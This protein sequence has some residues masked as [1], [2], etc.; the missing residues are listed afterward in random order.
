MK[1][2]A[3]IVASFA[4]FA[5]VGCLFPLFHV[6]PLKTA[7]AEKAA[8]TF[9]ATQFAETFW[10]NQLLPALNKTVPA[11]VLLPAIQNDAALAKKNFSRSVGLG[12]SYFYFIS[13]SG[14]VMAVSD[15]E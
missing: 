15:D 5:C 4:I 3:S 7:A 1:R 13:G 9:D 8:A 12:E 10:T 11:A 2:A 14:R 6:V